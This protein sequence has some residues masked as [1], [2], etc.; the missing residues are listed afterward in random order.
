MKATELRVGNYINEVGTGI[1][2]VTPENILY[3]YK[4]YG[5][6]NKFDPIKLT[7]EWMVRFKFKQYTPMQEPSTWFNMIKIMDK[8]LYS[9]G[10][11]RWNG[12]E[13]HV[14]LRYVHQLQ[15]LYFALTGEELP[16]KPNNEPSTERD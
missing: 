9:D 13:N 7:K 2:Q 16:T 5:I 3:L 12:R 15:N 14:I 11:Y 6:T 10:I 4:Q 1:I 8:S